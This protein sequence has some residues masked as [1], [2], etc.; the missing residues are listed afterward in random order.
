MDENEWK[1]LVGTFCNNVQNPERMVRQRS[2]KELLEQIHRELLPSQAPLVFEGIYLHVLRCYADRFEMV[3][4]LAITL[5]GEILDKLPANDFYLSYI[6]PAINHR[7]GQS[8][9]IEESEE[10][11]LILLEQLHAIIKKYAD[12]DGNRGDPLLKSYDNIIDILVKTLRDP[13]P[14]AQ[15]QSCEVVKLL[16]ESTPSMHYRAEALVSPATT[17]LR[18][19]H[20]ANRVASI[21]ALGI[22]ALHVHSSSDCVTKVIV[23]ISPLLM[24]SVPMVRMACGR[25][26]CMMLVKLRD[27]YSLFHRILPLVLNCLTDDTSEVRDDILPRWIEAGELYYKENESELAKI[28]LIDKL[29]ANYPLERYER[30]SLPCRAIVQRSLRIVNL[31]LYEM[32][33]WKEDIRLH[34]TK[35]LKLIILHAEKTFSTLFMEVNPVLCKACM[36][37]DKQVAEEALEVAR[38]CGILLDYDTWSRHAL[39]EFKK[40]PTLGHLRCLNAMY[41]SSGLDRF[42]DLLKIAIILTDTE[43]CHQLKPSYQL[44]LINFS[45]ILSIDYHRVHISNEIEGLAN[46]SDQKQVEKLLYTVVIKVAAFSHEDAESVR[47]RA[48]EI[49]SK[50]HSGEVEQLHDRHL[51]D[52]CG[53]LENLES[54]NS[55]TAESIMLLAGLLSVCGFRLAYHDA[56]KTALGTALKHAIPQGKIKLFSSISIAMLRWNRTMST[57]ADEQRLLLL[58]FI[59]DIIAPYLVWAAGRS[60]ESIRSMATACLCSISQGTDNSIFVT[61]LPNH[62]QILAGLVEDN[63]IATRAYSLRTLLAMGPLEADSFKLIAFAIV[64]RLDDPSGEVRELAAKC[65]GCLQLTAGIAGEDN[66]SERAHC[67]ETVL[68]PILSTMFLHLENPELKLRKAILDSLARLLIHHRELIKGL[69]NEVAPG[70]PYKKDLDNILV[71]Q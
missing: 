25:V 44:E 7:L 3:R 64:A 8:E 17:I 63:S 68:R 35:L 43:I 33:E 10:V 46:Q 2:L 57:S 24:D 31:V 66:G 71:H 56:L 36:D 16:A 1:M 54:S 32:E 58:S 28:R 52:V 42:K 22:L 37:M 39:A 53:S 30:P 47:E 26:G 55:D 4:T 60:A 6:V 34:A 49:L 61:I 69:A 15:K 14:A 23:D 5:I 48:L 38:L 19:R 45:D 59:E 65:L 18:H 51:A 40:F 27:R 13:Y 11:R 21:E 70:C 29:P 20:F 9:I 62:L 67:E 12:P 50:L 41:Q